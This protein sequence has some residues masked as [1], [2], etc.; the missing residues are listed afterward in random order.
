VI[1]LTREEWDAYHEAG[2]AVMALLLG[3]RV[4]N[5]WCG[6]RHDA[7]GTHFGHV[8]YEA[9][10]NNPGVAVPV[11]H[12]GYTAE[13]RLSEIRT[14][15][16]PIERFA[17]IESDLIRTARSAALDVAR[18]RIE[19]V[20]GLH[21]PPTAKKISDEAQAIQAQADS[22]A[23]AAFTHPQVWAMVE[24]IAGALL[25]D[26][27]LD[28]EKVRALVDVDAAK[29]L[30]EIVLHPSLRGAELEPAKRGVR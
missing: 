8:L 22:D 11:A 12:A 25:R 28:A 16:H 20:A 23:R 19:Q 1:E 18:T 10:D 17:G 14:A 6:V 5:I 21:R 3:C 29:H 2:H 30:G 24:N 13:L 26:R 15:Q 4:I 27:D 7:E 9:P